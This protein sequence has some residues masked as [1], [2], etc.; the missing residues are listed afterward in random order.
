[1]AANWHKWDEM[2]QAGS[3]ICPVL[4]VCGAKRPKLEEGRTST[5]G[6]PMDHPDDM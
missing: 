6:R 1:M 4:E 5:E 3:E 2:L